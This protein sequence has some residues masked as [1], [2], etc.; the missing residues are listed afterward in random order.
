GYVPTETWKANFGF[1]PSAAETP[2]EYSG[3]G[4]A[5]DGALKPDFMAL[6]GTLDESEYQATGYE[7]PYGLYGVS[8]GTSAAAPNGAGLIALLVSAAKQTNVPYDVGRLRAAL[9]TTTKFLPDVEARVQGR[10]LIQVNEAWAA[11]QRAAHWEPPEFSVEA[12]WVSAERSDAVVSRRDAKGLFEMGGW[13]PGQSGRRT[14]TIVRTSGPEGPVSYRLR[15]HE[16]V[17]EHGTPAFSSNLTQISLPLNQGVELPV[18]IRVGAAGSYSAI[19]DLIDPAADLVALSVMNTVLVGEP[20]VPAHHYE[21]KITGLLERPGNAVAWL[22][23]PPGLSALSVQVS[24]DDGREFYLLGQDPTGRL[25]PYALYGSVAHE[26]RAA[27]ADGHTAQTIDA[28]VPGLWQFWFSERNSQIKPAV[29]RL[30]AVPWRMEF[31]GL[32]VAA[33]APRAAGEGAPAQVVFSNQGADLGGARITGLGLGSAHEEVIRFNSRDEAAKQ[34]V[35]DVPKGT[36]RLEI[37]GAVE[38]PSGR[39]GLYVYKKPDDPSKLIGDITSLVYYDGSHESHKR[40]VLRQP[41]SGTYIVA[42]DPLSVP[43][44]GVRVRYRDVYFHSSFGEVSVSDKPDVLAT[45]A[46]RSASATVAVRARPAGDR[47][48]VA[49]VGLVSAEVGDLRMPRKDEAV[50]EEPLP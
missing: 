42:I 5:Q 39:I 49:S 31:R 18:Q 1:E 2:I 19:V 22:E 43:V 46:T 38:G 3:W 45:R 29:K 11:L 48:L 15:W 16:S 36:D 17:H 10:G 12:P 25:I 14:I 7:T 9:A 33:Q 34:L 37:E 32:R 13:R 4:P 23:V 21:A 35:I 44:G 40:Y 6:T 26:A 24:R 27:V 8:G 50:V 47:V 30:A 41:S 28:P 20:L